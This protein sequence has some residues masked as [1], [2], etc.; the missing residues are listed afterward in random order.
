MVVKILAADAVTVSIC[1]VSPGKDAGVRDVFRKEIAEPVD[2]VR[3]RPS[4]VSVSVQPVNG[5]NTRE[6]RISSIGR[7]TDLLD[8]RTV[9]IYQN[10][11][12]L[13]VCLKSFCCLRKA[14]SLQPDPA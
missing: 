12:T 2:A 8:N 11:E 4:L 7:K 9:S 13:R 10:L 5:N 3:G 6:I 14:V 1:I